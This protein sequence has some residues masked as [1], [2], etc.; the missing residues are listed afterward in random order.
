MDVKNLNKGRRVGL[1]SDVRI[2]K[3]DVVKSRTLQDWI[4]D[5]PVDIYRRV[6]VAFKFDYERL[7]VDGEAIS[8]L[9]QQLQKE[10]P[11]IVERIEK[12]K[13]EHKV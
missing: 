8:F 13:E 3:E 6:Y 7:N 12:R 1:T 9:K 4:L 10:H 5:D 11:E 2:E